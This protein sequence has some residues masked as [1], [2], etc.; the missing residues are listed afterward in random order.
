VRAL[1]VA[2]RLDADLGDRLDELLRPLVLVLHELL[3]A[4]HDGAVEPETLGDR[5][6]VRVARL[7]EDEA[8][9]RLER[10]VVERHGA[11]LGARVREGELLE[12]AQVRRDHGARARGEDLLEGR[13]T[14]SGAL[15]RVG[16]G[17]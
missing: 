6:G 3:G 7:A 14:E 11:V 10:L 16:P 12:R 13:A 15:E 17:A 9:S 1:A 5:D 8:I 2:L 4:L